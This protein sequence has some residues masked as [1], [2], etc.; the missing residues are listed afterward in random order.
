M[1]TSLKIADEPLFTADDPRFKEELIAQYNANCIQAKKNKGAC[2]SKR[3]CEGIVCPISEMIGRFGRS[4][5]T[6]EGKDDCK[7]LTVRGSVTVD[8]AALT[9]PAA[10]DA[11]EVG[12][13]HGSVSVGVCSTVA[14]TGVT[15]AV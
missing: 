14:C 7:V 3:P 9:A 4:A 8:V 15:F 10:Q 6:P 13:I 11:G 12:T 2:R 1:A 5:V